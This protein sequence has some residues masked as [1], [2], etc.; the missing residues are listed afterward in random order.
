V[1][2][3][4][5]PE[6]PV[7]ERVAAATQL[8]EIDGPLAGPRLEDDV[9]VRP[10]EPGGGGT[11]RQSDAVGLSFGVV[12]WPSRFAFCFRF[13][14]RTPRFIRFSLREAVINMFA[15]AGFLRNT[16]ILC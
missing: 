10:V 12:M 1:A 5:V 8:G 15:D 13:S 14:S 11:S 2:G 7:D 16:E 9:E 3:L 4:E 6:G